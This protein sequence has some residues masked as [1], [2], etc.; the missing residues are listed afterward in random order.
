MG[1]LLSKFRLQTR[2]LRILRRCEFCSEYKR[3]TQD[4]IWISWIRVR[5]YLILHRTSYM[6]ICV[7]CLSRCHF[8]G[9]GSH[10]A[11]WCVTINNNGITWNHCV[12]RANPYERSLRGTSSCSQKSISVWKLRRNGTAPADLR[13]ARAI[14]KQRMRP[15]WIARLHIGKK[16]HCWRDRTTLMATDWNLH[17]L[18]SQCRRSVSAESRAWVELILKKLEKVRHRDRAVHDGVNVSV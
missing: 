12:V 18:Q 16:I 15:T 7:T 10:R 9:M 4:N 5:S 3:S 17:E 1:T 14:E 6:Q 2:W 13:A 11:F 8:V